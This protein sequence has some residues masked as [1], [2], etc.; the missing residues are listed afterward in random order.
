MGSRITDYISKIVPSW[1]DFRVLRALTGQ[2]DQWV[3][4]AVQCRRQAFLETQDGPMLDY[5]GRN[6]N[7]RRVRFKFPVPESDAEYR[8]YLRTRWLRHGEAG[9]LDALDY[10]VRRW[11]FTNYQWVDELTLREAGYVGAFGNDADGLVNTPVTNSPGPGSGFFALIIR[12]PHYFQPAELW[13]VT[14]K[15]WDDADLWWDFAGIYGYPGVA[16]IQVLRELQSHI[17]EWRQSGASLRHIVVD[18][19][20]DCVV[21]NAA[22]YGYTGSSYAVYPCWE[23]EE[24]RTDGTYAPLYNLSWKVR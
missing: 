7:D 20:G 10:Q 22:T 12:P 3:D 16:P 8:A 14:T 17:G 13:D 1:I 23:L 6:S 24:L 5:T 15:K 4:D 2:A 9:T 21:D 18:F 19:V 11:G